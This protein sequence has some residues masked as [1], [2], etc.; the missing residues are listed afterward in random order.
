MLKNQ[1]KYI[2]DIIFQ[3]RVFHVP[4]LGNERKEHLLER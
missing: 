1:S 4:I 2:V 3:G